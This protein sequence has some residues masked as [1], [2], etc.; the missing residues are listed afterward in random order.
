MKKLTLEELPSQDTQAR[1]SP[2]IS[3]LE[4]LT[5]HDNDIDAPL[6]SLRH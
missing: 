6:F 4:A 3:F 5:R 2:F 1:R